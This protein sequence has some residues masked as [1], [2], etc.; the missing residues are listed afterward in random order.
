FLAVRDSVRF[1]CTQSIIHA[2]DNIMS[3]A[4]RIILIAQNFAALP[5]P[6]R[7]VACAAI[8]APAHTHVCPSPAATEECHLPA[9][10]VVLPA[11]RRA[12]LLR[13]P[14]NRSGLR[15]PSGQPRGQKVREP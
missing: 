8:L 5:V 6:L 11:N 9:L 3:V 13:Q 7:R 15:A 2:S 14:C 4:Q 10:P 12:S 1:V